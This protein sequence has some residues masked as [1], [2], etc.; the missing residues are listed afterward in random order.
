MNNINPFYIPESS[1]TLLPAWPLPNNFCTPRVQPGPD[2]NEGVT[3]LYL[4]M[5]TPHQ[6]LNFNE[7]T[8]NY[9]ATPTDTQHE[10]WERDH[11]R[12]ENKWLRDDLSRLCRKQEDTELELK[13]LKEAY[14][15]LLGVIGDL[16]STGNPTKLT[17]QLPQPI[18][19]EELPNIQYYT[20]KEYSDALQNGIAAKINSLDGTNR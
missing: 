9:N 16:G 8:H 13:T 5:D 14:D 11:Y 19:K 2:Y 6:R 20:K 15:K 10:W 3:Q 7:Y 18:L 12:E 4:Y 17:S 1:L